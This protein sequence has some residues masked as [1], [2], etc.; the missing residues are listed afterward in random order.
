MSFHLPTASPEVCKLQNAFLCRRDWMMI[1]GFARSRFLHHLQESSVHRSARDWGAGDCSCMLLMKEASVQC[2]HLSPADCCQERSDHQTT[3]F[4][5]R[6]LTPW[7]GLCI[8]LW[9]N[10][11]SFKY[12]QKCEGKVKSWW[13][14]TALLQLSPWLARYTWVHQRPCTASSGAFVA[15]I[16]GYGNMVWKQILAQQN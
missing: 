2:G 15:Q 3:S 10:S 12:L 7:I 1:R 5:L 14:G 11:Q 9:F 13:D 8:V 6:F 16:Y 4:L